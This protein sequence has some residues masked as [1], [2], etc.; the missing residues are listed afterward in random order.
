MDDTVKG[1][2]Q[3]LWGASAIGAAAGFAIAAALTYSAFRLRK[4]KQGDERALGAAP[5]ERRRL[6]LFCG[7]VKALADLAIQRHMSDT[8]FRGRLQ[9]L[10]CYDPLFPYFSESL[11]QQIA[12]LPDDQKRGGVLAVSCREEI[13]Q[14]ERTIGTASTEQA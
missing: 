2:L 13:E 7:D 11:R 6:L 4:P 12:G 9:A 10:P 14:L 8:I 5:Q 3:N 1:I